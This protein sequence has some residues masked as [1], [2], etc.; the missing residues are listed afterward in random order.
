MQDRTG[1]Y[2]Q[3]QYRQAFKM[4]YSEETILYNNIAKQGGNPLLFLLCFVIITS[5]ANNV[6][7]FAP[8]NG[9]M[10]GF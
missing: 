7:G 5:Y 1:N 3:K 6:P 9:Q 10:K 4:I 2:S 8:N